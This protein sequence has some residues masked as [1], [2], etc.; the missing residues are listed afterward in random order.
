[1]SVHGRP[2]LVDAVAVMSVL[3]RPPAGATPRDTSSGLRA[4]DG[5]TIVEMLV[6]SFVLALGVLGVAAL[7][8]HS[9]RTVAQADVQRDAT[10]IATGELEIIRS[11]DY[12]M[13]GIEASAVGYTP[14]VEGL[15]TVT[16]AA[17]NLVEPVTK[18]VVNGVTFQIE[19]SITWASID[20]NRTAYKVAI[21]VVE[22]ESPSGRQS[23]SMQTGLHEGLSND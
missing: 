23:I 2:R 21:V 6:S 4:D 9:A 13:V 10:S 17:G 16:E 5:V 12:D 11:L 22:W 20:S 18:V 1:M 15:P 7:L 8:S 3:R 19:R 14:T